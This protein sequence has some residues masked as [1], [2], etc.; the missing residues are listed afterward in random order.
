LN[1]ENGEDLDQNNEEAKNNSD[2]ENLIRDGGENE[3][4]DIV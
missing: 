2:N 1:H 3:E 4:E